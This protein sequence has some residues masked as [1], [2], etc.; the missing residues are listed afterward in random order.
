MLE[1]NTYDSLIKDNK[2]YN[3]KEFCLE[4]MEEIKGR[5]KLT[6]GSYFQ[7]NKKEFQ[8][9]MSASVKRFEDLVMIS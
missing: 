4:K 9:L 6:V 5:Y 3:Y 1:M 2:S 8:K 7:Y